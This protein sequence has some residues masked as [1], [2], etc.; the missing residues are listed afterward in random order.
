MWGV[1]AAP[2]AR[3]QGF[4]AVSVTGPYRHPGSANVRPISARFRQT[5]RITAGDLAA[6]CLARGRRPGAGA[7]AGTMSHQVK[8]SSGGCR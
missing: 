2:A 3:A 7:T 8:T 6:L 1:L 4:R 5:A